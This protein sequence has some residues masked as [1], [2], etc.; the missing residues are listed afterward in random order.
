[1]LVHIRLQ[2]GHL[3][4]RCP[5]HC[6]DQIQTSTV[7]PLTLHGCVTRI[8]NLRKEHKLGLQIFENK[9]M[10]KILVRVHINY[11]MLSKTSLVYGSKFR[12]PIRYRGKKKIETAQVR[13]LH[14]LKVVTS[15]GSEDTRN[16]SG[17]QNGRWH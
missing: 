16:L 14:R 15:N 2:D 5:K 10:R 7:L 13:F 1:M 6:E 11:N 12:G 4:A 9:V 17:S 8:F 3:P